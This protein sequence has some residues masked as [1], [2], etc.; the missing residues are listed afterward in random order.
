[1][2]LTPMFTNPLNE[3]LILLGGEKAKK[4]IAYLINLKKDHYCGQLETEAVK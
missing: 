1:M 2:I 4:T 3:G